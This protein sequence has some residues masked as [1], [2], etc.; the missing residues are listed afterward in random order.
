MEDEG[1]NSLFY[2]KFIIVVKFIMMSFEV[3]DV[4]IEVNL[5]VEVL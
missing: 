4:W 2:F 3:F 5:S 1:V